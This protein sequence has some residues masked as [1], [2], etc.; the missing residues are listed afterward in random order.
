MLSTV[1]LGNVGL[2]HIIVAQLLRAETSI[3]QVELRSDRNASF[4]F[5]FQRTTILNY[6]RTVHFPFWTVCSSAQ[7]GSF[8]HRVYTVA[9]PGETD[10]LGDRA[11]YREALGSPGSFSPRSD[12]QPHTRCDPRCHSGL[13]GCYRPSM[14]FTLRSM[15]PMAFQGKSST[16]GN[17]PDDLGSLCTSPSLTEL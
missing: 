11:G 13:C 7:Y 5:L 3:D 16:G 8:V 9:D 15:V 14:E 12:C 4:S 10:C 17:D 6:L 2:F 1:S